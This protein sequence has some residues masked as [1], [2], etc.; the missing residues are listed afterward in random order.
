L[1]Y[2]RRVVRGVTIPLLPC[3]PSP[4]GPHW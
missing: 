1:S 4:G 2:G 3:G